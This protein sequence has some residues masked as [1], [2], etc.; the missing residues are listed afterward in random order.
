MHDC[1]RFREN[2]TDS[3]LQSDSIESVVNELELRSCPGCQSYYQDALA[4]VKVIN[5]AVLPVELSDT[6]WNNFEAGL[7]ARLAN[8]RIPSSVSGTLRDRG[9]HVAV[10][11]AAATI[12][13]AFTFMLYRATENIGEAPAPQT[14]E[15]QFIDDQA[16]TLDPGTLDFL[17]QSEL[18]LRSFV[19]IE[20]ENV[21]DVNDARAWARRHLASL[22]QRKEAVVNFMPIQLV[23]DD[24]ETILRDIDNVDE[25]PVDLTDIQRRIERNGLIASLKT[26]QPRVVVTLEQ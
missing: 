1:Q 21:D 26:Y 23:L 22:D 19:K 7:R 2:L 9:M 24:Y 6:Y 14:T 11:T 4:V 17:G 20:P 15:I 13:L 8:E 12:V 18:F 16:V 25:S 5:S 3:V 10:F